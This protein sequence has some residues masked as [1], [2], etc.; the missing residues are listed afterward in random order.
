MQQQPHCLLCGDAHPTNTQHPSSR[1]KALIA[2]RAC[3]GPI[4]YPAAMSWEAESMNMCKACYQQLWRMKRG[5]VQMLP[6]DT[7]ILQM[8]MPG[9]P[10]RQDT[11]TK[12]RIHAALRSNG[13]V[14][15]QTLEVLDT[16][17]QR[18]REEQLD[19]WWEYNL[20]TEFFASKHTA[21]LLR[22]SGS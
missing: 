7:V 22:H 3:P 11:R 10:R 13:N 6:L 5:K 12:M 14:Y 18:P 8:M 20:R 9:L 15:S 21:R 2:A 16:L 4:A 17:L 19:A 1:V